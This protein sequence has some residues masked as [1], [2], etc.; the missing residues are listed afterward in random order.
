MTFKICLKSVKINHYLVTVPK[1]LVKVFALQPLEIIWRR[2]TSY[3]ITLMYRPTQNSLL[4]FDR[5]DRIRNRLQTI[6]VDL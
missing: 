5:V 3:F 4:R 1:V 2:A 6:I